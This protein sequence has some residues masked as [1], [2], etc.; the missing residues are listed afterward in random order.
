MTWFNTSLF[1]CVLLFF[2]S[3]TISPPYM[4][5]S[6]H[7]CTY[8][9]LL[10]V[11]PIPDDLMYCVD[12]RACLLMSSP[13]CVRIPLLIYLITLTLP[14]STSLQFALFIF[15]IFHPLSPFSIFFQPPFCLISPRTKHSQQCTMHSP[16]RFSNFF[17]CCLFGCR[18]N[19]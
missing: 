1:S 18:A 15:I 10:P 11:V 5:L 9:T 12:R 16:P 13:L 19:L 8:C 17:S 7:C 6:P 4:L 14:S 2:S 3:A